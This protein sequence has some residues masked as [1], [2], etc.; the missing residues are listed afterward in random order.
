MKMVFPF[1]HIQ[2]YTIDCCHLTQHAELLK[3]RHVLL[4]ETN[5]SPTKPVEASTVCHVGPDGNHQLYYIITFW[6][7][8][9]KN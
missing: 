1:T 4:G 5:S 8:S 3:P 9:S 7:K 6:N 2:H